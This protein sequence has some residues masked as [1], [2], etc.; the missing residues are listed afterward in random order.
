[1]EFDSIVL[2]PGREKKTLPDVYQLHF[3]LLIIDIYYLE[4]EPRNTAMVATAFGSSK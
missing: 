1:M 3:L 2:Y 4:E